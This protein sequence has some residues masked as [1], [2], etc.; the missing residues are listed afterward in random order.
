MIITSSDKKDTKKD[1]TVDGTPTEDSK[2][3]VSSGGV[4]EAI[5]DNK[6]YIDEV[7]QAAILK[8]M[9]DSY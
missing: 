7:I 5:Q 6:K 3:L 8:A 4:Y 2:N 9:T 1:F